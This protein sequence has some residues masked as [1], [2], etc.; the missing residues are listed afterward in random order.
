MSRDRSAESP[1]EPVR[2]DC[3]PEPSG[4]FAETAYC[5]LYLFEPLLQRN[6]LGF[7]LLQPL[8]VA[9]ALDAKRLRSFDQYRR[10]LSVVDCHHA[11]GTRRSLALETLSRILLGY[12]PDR[13][14][15]VL[16]PF[17]THAA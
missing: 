7:E 11:I 15:P 13:A 9:G 3:R 6:V 2:C 17:K 8:R 1:R 12:E 4:A 16:P 10:E 5:S 14:F